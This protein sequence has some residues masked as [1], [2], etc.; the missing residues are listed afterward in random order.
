M[1]T[2]YGCV[3]TITFRTWWNDQKQ[4]VRIA[5]LANPATDISSDLLPDLAAGGSDGDER[6]L[7]VDSTRSAYRVD[8]ETA[9]Q[10][11]N[12]RDPL[13]RWWS[14][15]T[16]DEKRVFI[17]NRDRRIP[18]KYRSSA[19]PVGAVTSITAGDEPPDELEFRLVPIAADFVEWKATQA[20][21]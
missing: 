21:E 19:L 10:I 2:V 9:E 8:D 17:S 11:Q 18:A 15:L 3:M 12:V 20:V 5:L 6:W 13:E 4:A 14:G 1:S 16:A 7:A